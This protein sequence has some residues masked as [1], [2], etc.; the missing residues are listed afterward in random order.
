MH[1]GTSASV[2][3][4]QIGLIMLGFL[5]IGGVALYSWFTSGARVSSPRQ[6]AVA[7]P[8]VEGRWISLGSTRDGSWHHIHSD[9]EYLLMHAGGEV[10][11]KPAG[12]TPYIGSEEGG[13]P[14]KR[15]DPRT[16]IRAEEVKEG[17]VCPPAR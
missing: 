3:G 6:E 16:R 10:V 2:K 5:F 4:W 8:P 15:L 17:K 12:C 7:R 14:V 1:V 9:K 13:I 11:R